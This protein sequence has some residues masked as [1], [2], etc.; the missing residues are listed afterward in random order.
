MDG[1]AS[2]YPS[3]DVAVF[4]QRPALDIDAIF[5]ENIEPFLVDVEFELGA[6]IG[7]ALLVLKQ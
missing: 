1:E 2:P 6:T 7:N 5:L 4:I 3:E